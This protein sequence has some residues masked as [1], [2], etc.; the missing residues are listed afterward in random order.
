M[1][2]T[3]DDGGAGYD[4]FPYTDGLYYW[5]EDMN[6]INYQYKWTNIDGI[7]TYEGIPDTVNFPIITQVR[8]INGNDT[9]DLPDNGTQL[10]IGAYYCS[11]S[12]QPNAIVKSD[13]EIDLY[14]S[15]IVEGTDGVIGAEHKAFRNIFTIKHFIGTPDWTTPIRYFVS[16]FIE[17]V[18]P[19]VSPKPIKNNICLRSIIWYQ[20]DNY[21]G[22]SQQP[23]IGNLHP[24]VENSIYYAEEPYVDG[25]DI[26]INEISDIKNE[27]IIYPNPAKDKI[28]VSIKEKQ[29]IAGLN[30]S[31][32]NIQG[33]LLLQQ[34]IT[35][36][37]SEIAIS[38]LLQ[39]IYIAKIRMSDGSY[40]QKK[41]VVVK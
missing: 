26:G 9:I 29:S 16:N 41:F 19:C 1:K 25:C 8:D 18:Y 6:T 38:Q 11:M 39:G 31:I 20:A 28:T 37:K 21:P 2:N 12:S 22:I 10:S 15:S 32:Y 3:D 40:R 14:Y 27:P 33:Q 23:I 13:G 7:M 24:I 35:Q 4:Y 36:N 34:N 30:L 17:E 5:N